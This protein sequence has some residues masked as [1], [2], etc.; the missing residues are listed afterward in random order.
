MSSQ[1]RLRITGFLITTVAFVFVQHHARAQT[2]PP[3]P[4]LEQP[5]TQPQTQPEQVPLPPPRVTTQ[6]AV[7][8]RQLFRTAFGTSPF[9]ASRQRLTRAPDMF[10]DMLLP[11]PGYILT[12]PCQ[13]VDDEFPCQDEMTNLSLIQPGGGGF[14][15]SDN[16]EVLPVDRVFVN[17]NHFHNAV[18]LQGPN[19]FNT[20]N[21]NRATLGVEKMFA[22][23]AHSIEMRLPFSGG[24]DATL[25][26][27]NL[28]PLGLSGGD[29]GNLTLV[30]KSLIYQDSQ[31]AF[32]GGLALEIPTGD[33]LYLTTPNDGTIQFENQAFHLHPYLGL[34]H[35][36]EDDFFFSTYL[37]FDAGLNDNPIYQT[38]N[39][40]Q[41]LGDAAP[42]SLIMLDVGVGKWI[43]RNLEK[44]GIT[45]IAPLV[46]LHYLSTI[47]GI[48]GG[49]NNGVGSLLRPTRNSFQSLN[50]TAGVHT[51][52][53]GF[54][55]LRVAAVSPLLGQNFR[56][57]DAEIQVQYTIHY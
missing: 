41:R 1:T 56:A 40:R 53:N 20:G 3:P 22:N 11:G 45:G 44:D 32:G 25:N 31:T 51:E 43:Y 38:L 37:Q 29:L 47:D 36:T 13:L 26:R 42:L 52:I 18:A 35:M 15:I 9:S 23:G 5:R 12:E 24:V 4:S 2:V 10:G 49:G 55:A 28:A 14:K 8:R 50:L 17:Y 16:G 7:A 30:F 46:E 33:D 27:T 19:S 57:F 39:S 54:S 21:Y 6:P 34:L 48:D